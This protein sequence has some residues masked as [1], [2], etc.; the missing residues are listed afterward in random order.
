ML[1]PIDIHNMEFSRTFKGY[2]PDEVD[3]FLATIV[4]KY[5]ELYQENK[6]LKERLAKAEADLG[7]QA[8]QEQDVQDLISLTKQTVQELKRMAETEAA[9][10]VAVAKSDAERIVSE[11]E[12]KAERL[13]SD[14]E[15]RLARTRQAEVELREKI[16]ITMETIWNVLTEDRNRPTEETR[17]YQQ[18]AAG[19]EG[20]DEGEELT[21]E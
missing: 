13:L 8:Y 6:E 4:S 9:N 18:I 19:F 11:A 5:E 15:I 17:P 1:R 21:S 12:R 2:N 3:E 20:T 14:V 7:K 16:R 10:V